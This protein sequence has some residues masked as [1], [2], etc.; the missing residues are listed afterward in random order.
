MGFRETR[1]VVVVVRQFLLPIGRLPSRRE[2]RITHDAVQSKSESERAE[3]KI[4]RSRIK[5]TKDYE[6][7]YIKAVRQATV[8]LQQMLGREYVHKCPGRGEK[9]QG[10]KHSN[11]N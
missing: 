4:Q 7:I 1:H 8:K 11:V 5:K 10:M 3:K 6:N 9:L 2:I